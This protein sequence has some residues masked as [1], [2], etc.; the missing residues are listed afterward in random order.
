MSTLVQ[1]IAKQ[2]TRATIKKITPLG[3]GLINDTF[4]VHTE[5]SCFV[6]QRINTQ[7]FPA[8]HLIM[9]NLSALKDHIKVTRHTAVKL[10]IPSVL[11]TVDQQAYYLDQES[12]FWRSLEFIDNSVSKEQIS[13][14]SQAN[15]VGYA[16]GHFHHL[17][18]NADI[19]LF[20]DTLPGFHITPKYFLHY[21]AVEKNQANKIQSEKVRQC[22]DFI[23]RFEAKINNLEKAKQQGLLTERI[24]H[25]DPKLNNFLFAKNT[26]TI[27]SLIDLDTVKP[28][29]VHYDIADCLRSCCHIPHSNILDLDLCEA[30]LSPYLKETT[31]FFTEHD[32]AFLYSAIELIPFELGLRF[33]TDYL[34]GNQYFKVEFAEQNLERA[35]AQFQLCENIK[36]Q[37]KR[38]KQIIADSKT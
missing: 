21:Q 30:I 34:E 5:G 32:Y 22:K 35:L 19:S 14:H 18:H 12:C 7:V 24:T 10:S 17:L 13:N 29:L 31:T 25:G 2:F 16:L 6:L 28:G 20:H 27:I 26:D 11:K 1:K 3:N 38:I 37:E 23:K 36:E 8:P 15:Q 33:F 4:L 9:E